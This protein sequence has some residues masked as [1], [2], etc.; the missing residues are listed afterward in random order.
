MAWLNN[1][2]TLAYAS[3]MVAFVFLVAINALAGNIFRSA[4]VDLTE[5]R[6][7]SL[8]AGT[9][10]VLAD[11]DEPVTLRYFLSPKLEQ[12]V[13]AYGAY[14]ARVRNVLQRF[15]K[16][17]N[18]KIRLEEYR[19]VAFSV[20]EDRAV[21]FGLRGVPVD[22]SGELVFFGLAGTNTT[23]DQKTIAFFHPS[24]ERFIEFDLTRMIRSLATPRKKVV[25]LISS[26]P[27][28]GRF[29]LRGMVR[30]WAFY[31]Q[32]RDQFDVR[33][34]TAPKK[35][36]NDVDV[37]LIVHPFR[38]PEPTLYAI[39][40]YV[41]N[42]GKAIILVDPVPEAAPR[43]RTMFGQGPVPPGS[44][45]PRLFKSWGIELVK[46]KVVADIQSA[47]RVRTKFQ[48]RSVVA[49]Y[50]VWI[51]LNK[52]SLN[53]KDKVTKG[54]RRT[55]FATAGALRKLK[56][57]TTK[58]TPLIRTRKHASLIDSRK[59]RFRPDVVKLYQTYKTDRRAYVVAARIT[60]KA[61]SAFPKGNPVK[62][63][64]KVEKKPEKKAEKKAAKPVGKKGAA[65][66]DKKASAKAKTK[67]AA[68]PV[69][70]KTAAKPIDV[71]VVADVDWLTQ[72]YWQST[73]NFFGERITVPT[74]DN[75]NF[76]MNALDTM[77]GVDAFTGL[78][79]KGTVQRPFT[80]IESLKKKAEEKQRATR[81][82][83]VKELTKTRKALK[84]AR[85]RSRGGKLVLT[86]EERKKIEEFRSQLLRIRRDLRKVKFEEQKDIERE[87]TKW[88]RINI[89][90]LPLVICGVALI[91][92]VARQRRRRR[93]AVAG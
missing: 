79:A 5:D 67:K 48:G 23:D 76:I 29:S 59:I 92:G 1:R 84:D 34:L 13:P 72:G 18:G 45:M 26:L 86:A 91:V 15:V 75:A 40:Q 62:P 56:G 83:L 12:V 27:V 71:I 10:K 39:D 21:A 44:D 24:R 65:K 77:S 8:S 63:K 64:K 57:A 88:M 7:Y 31:T 46:G 42:G 35:I 47:V 90:L 69:H 74:S 3:L 61:A 93:K 60:G 82:E 85:T 36:P 2:R 87:Q 66:S 11:M 52:A 80:K 53:A 49:P 22:Q 51:D 50:V 55:I 9:R 38:I 25:G 81:G 30:P 32:I 19:P 28:Q 89:G 20:E 14:A 54:L 73:T 68:P 41:L 43:R 6:L 17:S 37:L 4:A 33:P 58:V 78:R 70:L 16:L